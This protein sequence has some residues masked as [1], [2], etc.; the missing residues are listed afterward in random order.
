VSLLHRF[1]IPENSM[2]Y[3]LLASLL[4]ALVLAV[5]A[6]IREFRLR[7]ALERLCSSLFVHLWRPNVHE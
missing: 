6:L 7:N 4:L 5:A 3:I 1:I 2:I